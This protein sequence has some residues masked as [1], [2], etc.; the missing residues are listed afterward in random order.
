VKKAAIGKFA[1]GTESLAPECTAPGRADPAFTLV[2]MLLVVVLLATLTGTLAVSLRGRVDRHALRIAG[3]D[4]AA[5]VRFSVAE[6]RLNRLPYRV[7]FHDNWTCYRVERAK[8][9]A[10]SEYVPVR[11]LAGQMKAFAK[12]VR[13]AGASTDG[14]PLESVPEALPQYPDG[15]GF[16]GEI[17]L[18]NRAGETLTIKV[19]PVTGQVRIVE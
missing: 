11:S 16:H 14:Q 13:I 17:R 3:K 9:A 7:A 15:N 6:A 18:A 2:E 19:A 4:L 1:V 8:S 12:Q 5:A 10:G